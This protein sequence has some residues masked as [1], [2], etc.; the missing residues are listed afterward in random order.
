MSNISFGNNYCFIMDIDGVYTDAR[1]WEKVIPKENTREGWD[2][3]GSKVN[4]SKPNKEIINIAKGLQKLLP[5]IFITSREDRGSMREFTEHEIRTYSDGEINIGTHNK[6]FMRK[7]NDLRSSAEVK[8]ELLDE[9]KKQGYKPVLAIDDSKENIDM[10]EENGIATK[11][12]V[13][14]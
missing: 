13:L 14:A 10:F 8:Q 1:E 6:L 12:Y 7:N 5:I 3:Y 9:V 11:L 2:Y 4:L